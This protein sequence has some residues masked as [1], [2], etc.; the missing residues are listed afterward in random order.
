MR[1]PYHVKFNGRYYAP[2]EE[3]IETNGDPGVKQEQ[4]PTNRPEVKPKGRR[5]NKTE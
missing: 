4:S 2:N 1:Y 5:G 3:I